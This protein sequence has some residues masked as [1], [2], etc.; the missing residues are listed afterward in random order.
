MP[1]YIPIL[2]LVSIPSY[3][4]QKTEGPVQ[5]KKKHNENKKYQEMKQQQFEQ[6]V[7]SKNINSIW[8]QLKI[9]QFVE[10]FLH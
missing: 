1:D 10:E 6:K 9:Q 2:H 7:K 5:D 4:G 3:N 8:K